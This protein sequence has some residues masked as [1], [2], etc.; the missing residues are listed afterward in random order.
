MSVGATALALSAASY[1]RVMGAN[2]RIGI[3]LI[4]CGDRGITRHMLYIKSLAKQTNVEFTAVCDPWRI[5]RE[6]AAAEVKTTYGLD[7]EQYVSHRE[8]LQSKRVDAVMIASCDHLHTTHL[9]AAAKAKKHVYCEKPLAMEFDRLKKACDAVRESGVVFQAGTQ[10]RS[11]PSMVGTRKLYQTGI[12]GTV[13]LIDEHRNSASPYWY[14]YVK[15][16]V[17]AEDVDWAEFLGDRPMRP[18]DPVTF[19]G[20]YGYRDFSGG[21]VPGWGSHFIDLV[22]FITGA[23][24]PTSAVCL[25]GV[26][27]WRDKYKFDCPDCVQAIWEYPEGFQVRYSTNFGNGSGS[28]FKFL[29][30]QGLLDLANLN[31]PVLTAEG[32]S[33]NKGVIRGVT[34]IEKVPTPH[35]V[36]NWLQCVRS[37]GTPAA[38]IEVA[39]QNAVA[40]LMA[41]GAFNTGSRQVYDPQK[42]EIRNG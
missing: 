42:L 11:E 40:I 10:L 7:A 2:E 3:G 27:T 26:Y 20:W 23:K 8:L 22:H 19:S 34:P 16:D 14:S 18:F 13:G 32:G 41:M 29:G 31:E 33:K 30:N 15:P 12:L 9:E 36:L 39:Y 5:R 24:F 21:P 1:R 25:G 28:S 37:N 38:N 35:H 4:G 17:R 6:M